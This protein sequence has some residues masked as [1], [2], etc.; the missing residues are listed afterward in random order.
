MKKNNQFLKIITYTL[1][2]LAFVMG[3]TMLGLTIFINPNNYKPQIT[4]SVEDATRRKL[5]ISGELKWKFFPNFGIQ[6]NRLS[7]SNPDGFGPG[8]FAE[9]NSV[10]VAVNILPLL[11]GSVEIDHLVINGL[12]LALI[13]K[14]KT[15]NW[16]FEPKS[17]TSQTD[18][19][20]SK[21]K[22]QLNS[23]NL[24]N[25]S[26]SYVNTLN[27]TQKKVSNFSLSLKNGSSGQMSFDKF[28]DQL[29]FKNVEF[30]LNHILKGTL[31]LDANLS[32]VKYNGDV[33][34]PEFSLNNYLDQI[35]IA[36]PKLHNPQLLNKVAYKTNF[37]GTTNSL[38]LNNISLQIGSSNFAGNIILQS[39]SPLG[40]NE[41]ININQMD[42]SDYSDLNGFKLPMKNLSIKGNFLSK[43]EKLNA[44]QDL[45]IQNLT[46]LGFNVNSFTAKLD[47]ITDM[48][49]VKVLN[50][51]QATSIFNSIQ[52]QI[53]QLG[54]PGR[55]DLA[56]KTDLGRLDSKIVV[57]N[58]IL[59]TPL[60]QLVGPHLITTGKGTVNLSDKTINYLTY[61]KFLH[62]NAL[63]NTLIF[64]YH[65]QG[66][67]SN[68]DGSLDWTSINQQ[69][70]KFY[71][72]GG[73]GKAIVNGTENAVKSTGTFFKNL[74]K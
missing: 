48:G 13:D 6:S 43:N 62:Q 49:G 54:A 12:K 57:R 47:Q 65:M 36:R 27:H 1:I 11:H 2:T 50:V 30:S 68:I 40:G 74:F 55:K 32:S 33:N 71:T 24:E 31:N 17:K 41:E 15:N 44:E 73:I 64:P 66:K 16:T 4:K 60:F 38:S 23:F 5:T 52:N 26:L 61:T 53:K 3:G 10:I 63:L 56:Q 29:K 35:G 7:L 19:S 67:L 69:I 37:T 34:I 8:N 51:T 45:S 58:D 20:K 72:S 21:F 59:T 39:I 25:S 9:L 70:I 46:L 28:K 22:L 42:L 18:N 14:G